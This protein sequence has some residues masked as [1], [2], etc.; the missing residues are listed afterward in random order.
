MAGKAAEEDDLFKLAAQGGGAE[1]EAGLPDDGVL[2]GADGRQVTDPGFETRVKTPTKDTKE[3]KKPRGRMPR[4]SVVEKQAADIA[5]TLEEKFAV[6]FGLLTT[7]MPVTGVYGTENAPKA[8]RA[9]LDIGKRR[10]AVMR[11]LLRVADG[12]DSLELAKFV[13]GIACAVQVDMGRMQGTEVPARAFGVTDI[14]ER[15]FNPE[16]QPKENPNVQEQETNV[17]RFA[18][19]S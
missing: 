14:L 9:L 5:E 10:P 7:A 11:A 4:G 3:D 12:A 19:V 13:L 2:L 8:V 18:P 16:N 15:F 17:P 1:A 6:I